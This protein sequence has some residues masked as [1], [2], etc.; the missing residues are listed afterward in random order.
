MTKKMCA[1]KILMENSATVDA[2]FLSLSLDQAAGTLSA[3][4]QGTIVYRLDREELREKVRGKTTEEIREIMLSKPE[5][6]SL[7][8]Q[9]SP[10][11]VKSAP[12]L[13][14]KIKIVTAD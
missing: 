11:W 6:D 7:E 3:H 10:F 2:S 9:F 14:P 12:K 5:I 1:K 4:F 8:V 13:R